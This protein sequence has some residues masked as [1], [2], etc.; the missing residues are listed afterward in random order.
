[1]IEPRSPGDRPYGPL[2]VDMLAAR[3]VDARVSHHGR[4]F[5]MIH[6]VT[7]IWERVRDGQPD[8]LVLNFGIIEAQARVVPS[9][10]MAHL[11]GWRRSTHP[12][13]LGYRDHVAGRAWV[14]IREAQRRLGP[15]VTSSHRL[16]PSRFRREVQQLAR[17]ARHE[18][19]AL[20]LFV[21]LDP[22]GSRLVHW[23]PDQPARVARFNEVLAA[24]VE[25][26]DDP[27][28]RVVGA[29]AALGA[30]EIDE[31]LPDGLHRTAEG[32]RRTAALLTAEIAPW[33]AALGHAED[34]A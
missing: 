10:V 7:P 30:N 12:M 28:V 23:L 1:M 21:D 27:E 11:T 5:G 29:G 16:S 24:A 14:G 34:G 26:L 17:R 4:W 20:V 15:R 2:A 18:L 25:D 31:V 32:H 3:G 6:Q 8:V 19:G 13:A 9:K 33:W 22:P